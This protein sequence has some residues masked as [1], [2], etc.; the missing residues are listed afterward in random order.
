MMKDVF[1]KYRNALKYFDRVRSACSLLLLIQKHYYYHWMSIY[2][3]SRHPKFEICV[4]S[5]MK[6]SR[7]LHRTYH[8]LILKLILKLLVQYL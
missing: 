5:K 1:P 2:S 3:K 8:I 4:E 6:F 7:S